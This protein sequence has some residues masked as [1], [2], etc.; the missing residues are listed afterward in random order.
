MNGRTVRHFSLLLLL[1]P[2]LSCTNTDAPATSR[3]NLQGTVNEADTDAPIDGAQVQLRIATSS[4][5]GAWASDSTRGGDFT[6]E[7]EVPGGCEGRDSVDAVLLVEAAG[8]DTYDTGSAGSG[9]KVACQV[10]T[11]AVAV[12]LERPISRTPVEVYGRL[13]VTAVSAGA[14]YAC[15]MTGGGVYCWG[16]NSEVRGAAPG[17]PDT[18]GTG[19]V[20][21]PT[22]VSGGAGLMQVSANYKVAC[23]LDT[24]STAYCWGDNG[25]GQLGVSDPS[26]R[27]ADHAMRVET[28]IRFV[29]IAAG[30]LQACGLTAQGAVYCWG[31]GA[32]IGAGDGYDTFSPTP[33]PIASTLT[34]RQISAGQGHTCALDDGGHAWCWGRSGDGELGD[35]HASPGFVRTPQPVTGGHL[36]VQIAAGGYHACGL[37]A[38]GAAWCWG[39]NSDAQIGD[40]TGGQGADDRLEPVA[41]AGGR[42][43][44]ALS[45]G[46]VHTCG[47]AS[48][49]A[50]YCWGG[51]YTG[52]LGAETD[53]DCT[54]ALATKCARQ[55]MPVSGGLTYAKLAAG[56]GVTCGTTPADRLYCWGLKAALGAG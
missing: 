26:V 3:V 4:G 14:A 40:G 2:L 44:L 56:W 9:L 48:D 38:T 13:R 16:L 39:R 8:F 7:A 5:T 53:A 54:G 50:A 12:I 18:D 51:D 22:H 46:Y 17:S 36:F 20:A 19:V 52:D 23:G 30:S 43:F 47:I 15:A 21:V 35:G 27:W 33:T 11:Q 10:E 41:V 45:G 24:D 37:T 1:G 29:Q 42:T 32:T 28:N 34:F 55:P 49:G 31:N 25:Y 6:I